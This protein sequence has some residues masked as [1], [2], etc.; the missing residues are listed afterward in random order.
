MK[1]GDKVKVIKGDYSG[2]VGIIKS[3]DYSHRSFGMKKYGLKFNIVEENGNIISVDANNVEL[4]QDQEEGT[5][6]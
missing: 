4:L 1:P 6:E 5:R 2:R 3:K